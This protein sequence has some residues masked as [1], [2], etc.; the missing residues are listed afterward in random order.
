MT[1]FVDSNNMA[2]VYATPP[3][4][5]PTYRDGQ[6]GKIQKTTASIAAAAGG[7]TVY[8]MARVHSNDSIHSLL[9]GNTANGGSGAVT[10]GLY[11]I[12]GG[13]VV[14]AALFATGISTVS[15]VAP[16][17]LRY[18][19]LTASTAGQRIWE[20][21]SLTSDPN[22]DYDLTITLTTNGGTLATVYCEVH[23]TR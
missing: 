16:A 3:V 11:N 7:G 2:N 17:Q 20:L 21:L 1:T 8:R 14:S 6:T 19:T 22:L 9:V 13:A 5:N 12:N 10:V 4:L 15:A 23:T 18:S